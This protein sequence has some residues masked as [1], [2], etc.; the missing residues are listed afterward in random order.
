MNIAL[1][2]EKKRELLI[3]AIKSIGI[4]DE[5]VLQAFR[6]VAR[7]EFVPYE[8][9]DAAYYDEPLP[10]GEGQ[11]ISQPS[12]V[13]RMTEALALRGDEKVLEIGTG[14]GF[15]AAILAKLSR[16]VYTIE[17][18]ESLARRARQTLQRMGFSNVHVII[19][20]G[21][22]GLREESPFDAIVV[23]AGAPDIPKPLIDQLR[24]GG[25]MVIPIGQ[26]PAMQMLKRITKRKGG[27]VAEDIEFVSF[28]PL[29]G[30]HGW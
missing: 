27:L 17:R 7:H 8:L 13:A 30:E 2:F 16:V 25:R 19:G 18:I 26:Y 24:E 5:R 15:Q 14:S 3:E 10:I 1:D 21:T 20:N 28:V 9:R 11:V 4:T 6:E 29:I 22:L 12:L 23:T